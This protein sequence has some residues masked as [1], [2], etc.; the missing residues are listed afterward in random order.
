MEG[1]SRAGHRPLALEALEITRSEKQ[2]RVGGMFSRQFRTEHEWSS[3]TRSAGRGWPVLVEGWARHTEDITSVEGHCIQYGQ[4][5]AAGTVFRPDIGEFSSV[6]FLG[7]SRQRDRNDLHTY[8]SGRNRP[9]FV[10]LLKQP[11]ATL[12]LIPLDGKPCGCDVCNA[13]VPL[14]R[15]GLDGA[16]LPIGPGPVEERDSLG[17]WRVI[18]SE[19]QV[20]ADEA[21]RYDTLLGRAIRELDE[22]LQ[23]ADA[24]WP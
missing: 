12:R 9:Q 5:V 14:W 13:A 8:G 23:S 15:V 21:Q 1:L 16:Q 4:S 2:V 7:I 6:V 19:P 24:R 22:N 18:D 17:R 20:I 10:S 11:T 3:T